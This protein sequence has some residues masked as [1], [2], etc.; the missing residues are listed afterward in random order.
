MRAVS[1]KIGGWIEK[2]LSDEEMNF[3]WD[4]IET[5]GTDEKKNLA[6]QINSSYNI[7]DKNDWFFKN[8]LQQLVLTYRSHFGESALAVN[9][10]HPYYLNRFWVNYQKQNEFNPLH[11]HGGIYSFVIWM[12]IPTYYSEQNRNLLAAT[13]NAKKISCFEFTYTNMLGGVE[14]YTYE[15]TP[16]HEGVLVFFPAALKHMVYP[17]YNCNEDRISISGNIFLD[18]TQSEGTAIDYD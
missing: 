1:P 18:T 11:N 10:L 8:T 12:K 4:A 3:L 14:T 6:G 16:E 9:Q 15:L 2:D 13:A 17:F 5:K 7:P